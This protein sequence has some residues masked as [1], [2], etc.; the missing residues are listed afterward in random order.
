M[1]TGVSTLV[2]AGLAVASAELAIDP[3]TIDYE[4][5]NFVAT[6]GRSYTTKDEYLV[7]RANFE[8]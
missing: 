3:S 1:R 2:V 4:F 6:Y 7:R 8:A 5:A